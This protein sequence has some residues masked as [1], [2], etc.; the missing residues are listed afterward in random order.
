MSRSQYEEIARDN[1]EGSLQLPNWTPSLKKRARPLGHGRGLTIS[2]IKAYIHLGQR[3]MLLW[4]GLKQ[5][6]RRRRSWINGT[7]AEARAE[8]LAILK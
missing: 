2:C 1:Y 4:A 8:S 6:C 3:P 5:L 7:E